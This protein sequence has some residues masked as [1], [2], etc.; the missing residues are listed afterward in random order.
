MCLVS[1]GYN[2]IIK[3]ILEYYNILE[4][5]ISIETPS[6]Y[7]NKYGD[8]YFDGYSMNDKNQMIEKIMTINKFKNCL[9]VDDSLFNVI[10]AEK[11]GY[12]TYHVKSDSGITV[13]DA[14][15][16]IK[17]INK[18]NIDIIFIDADKTLFVEHVTS[19]YIYKLE[20]T[21]LINTFDPSKATISDGAYILIQNMK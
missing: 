19:K 11:V 14:N 12:Y 10:S 20:R 7:K 6:N 1:F 4:Y 5:F 13:E 16:I 18:N 17:I 21:N 15:E 2:Q 9:L 8:T 3:K